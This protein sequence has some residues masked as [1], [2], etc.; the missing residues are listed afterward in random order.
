MMNKQFLDDVICVTYISGCVWCTSQL[1]GKTQNLHEIIDLSDETTSGSTTTH[2]K[3]KLVWRARVSFNLEDL[4]K[5]VKE[6]TSLSCQIH[7]IP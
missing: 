4:H 3:G 7:C 1:L 2:T 5:H 6:S